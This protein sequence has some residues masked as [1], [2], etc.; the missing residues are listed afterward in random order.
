LQA[1]IPEASASDFLLGKSQTFRLPS[2]TEQDEAVLEE[3]VP[4][5]YSTPPLHSGLISLDA[6]DRLNEEVSELLASNQNHTPPRKINSGGMS[7]S[8]LAS[9]DPKRVKRI[10]ANR[11]SAARSKERKM[12]YMGDLEA[13]VKKLQGELS[14]LRDEYKSVLQEVASSAEESK[15]LQEQLELLENSSRMG[16]TAESTLKAELSGLQMMAAASPLGKQQQQQQQQQQYQQQQ[17]LYWAQQSPAAQT[18]PPPPLQQQ[19]LMP[20]AAAAEAESHSP[21]AV[22][23][24]AGV[25]IELP[26][27]TKLELPEGTTMATKTPPPAANS[28]EAPHT[29]VPTH[30][31]IP[32]PVEAPSPVSPFDAE[33][34]HGVQ[35]SSATPMEGVVEQQQPPLASFWDRAH[36]FPRISSSDLRLPSGLL[37]LSPEGDPLAGPA[38]TDMMDVQAPDNYPVKPEAPSPQ[39]LTGNSAEQQELESWIQALQKVG[40]MKSPQH[41]LTSP[42]ATP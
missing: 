34:I 6:I 36:S 30:S 13:Q 39:L 25:I 22:K 16:L 21:N 10:L 29:A 42:C 33:L 12:R 28:K 26:D 7:L 37:W 2:Q 38:A 9:M 31:R 3:S 15:V 20:P 32:E 41:S 17:Q 18:Q 1:A 27:G 23:L 4:D 40:Y 5:G 14:G 8:E 11:Q 35:G 19:H 24:P